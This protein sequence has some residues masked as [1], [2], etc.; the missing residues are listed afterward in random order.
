MRG[1]RVITTVSGTQA[2]HARSAGADEVI[3]YRIENVGRRWCWCCTIGNCIKRLPQPQS[4]PRQRRSGETARLASN[5]ACACTGEWPPQL[6]S[7]WR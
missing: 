5:P 7:S 4:F 3:N 6:T 1:A 2:A